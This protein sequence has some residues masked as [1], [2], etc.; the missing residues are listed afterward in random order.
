MQRSRLCTEYCKDKTRVTR[1]AY[2]KQRN[3]CVSI[4]R[5]SLKSYYEKL[6]AKNIIDNKKI[7]VP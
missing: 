4:L 1:I 7:C 5:K 6:N 3:V 2:N